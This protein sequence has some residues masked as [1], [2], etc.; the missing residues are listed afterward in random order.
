MSQWPAVPVA[1]PPGPVLPALNH[2]APELV[3]SAHSPWM[4][5]TPRTP[6]LGPPFGK[7]VRPWRTPCS[8]VTVRSWPGRSRPLVQAHRPPRDRL[9]LLRGSAFSFSLFFSGE[10]LGENTLRGAARPGPSARILLP[11]LRAAG[12]RSA[13]GRTSSAPCFCCEGFSQELIFY[14]IVLRDEAKVP[15]KP[16][17]ISLI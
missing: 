16:R 4:R 14:F 6:H 7:S 3:L 17:Y 13:A 15:L 12:G 9:P 2:A 1:W 11:Q 10:S 8:A 5:P